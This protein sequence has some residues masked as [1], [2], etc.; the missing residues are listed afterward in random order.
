MINN[1]KHIL[2]TGASSGI[3][4]ET[5]KLLISDGYLLTIPCRNDLRILETSK[6]FESSL[7]TKKDHIAPRFPRVDLADL[8]NV[9]DFCKK[10]LSRNQPIDVLIL[11][12]GLQYTGSL[13]PRYSPQGVELTFAVNHV[14]N[15]FLL[16]NL[17]PLLR[18]SKS[19]KVI[20]TSSEVHNPNSSGGRIGKKAN[21]VS[22][23]GLKSGKGFTTIDNNEF[24]ADKAYKDSKL[25]NILLAREFYR[26]TNIINFKIPVITWAP[27]LVI[28]M[29]RGGFFRY[30]RQ[31]NEL[32]QRIFSIIARDLLRISVSPFCAGKLLYQIVT[33]SIYDKPKFSYLSNN[34]MRPG[35]HE[36]I[37]YSISEQALDSKLALELWEGTEE[38]ICKVI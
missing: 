4:H 18:L 25:C 7:N 38:L 23:D 14:A 11:N 34:L 6:K 37:E 13:E 21:I 8:S 36:F 33:R 9:R 26:R 28:P 30:S 5:A 3:G 27:G 20:I 31:Y 19:P 16:Q 1:H 24:N 2:I 15:Q 29:G 32:G 10:L 12:A 35:K 22:L 17:L